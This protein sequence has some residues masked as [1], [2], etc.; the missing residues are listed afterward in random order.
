VGSKHALSLLAITLFATTHVAAQQTGTVSGTVVAAES[1]APLAGASVVMVGTARAVLTN[2]KGEYRLSVPAGAHSVRARHFGY[3]AGEQRITVA[4]GQTATADF[5]LTATPLAL[6]EV[7]VLGA[8]T[9]RTAVETPVPVDV[10]STQEIADNG[11]TEV[12][13]ILTT[14]APSFNASH[15]TI[16]DGTDH[17]DP[18]SL[19]GLGPDQVLVLVNGKRRHSSALVNVNGTFGR[20]TVGV[21]LNAIPTAAI[22]RIEVL[23]DGAAAQYGSDA[24]AGVINIVLKEQAEH[25]ELTTT[26]GT[27]SGGTTVGDITSRHDGDQIRTE[28]DYG[29]RLG[30]RGFFNVAG[31][32][33]HRGATSRAAPYSGND[34]FRGVTT[35]AGTDS[36]LLANG[37]T[38]EDFTIRLGQSAATVGMAFYNTVVPLSENAEFY[39]FGGI[40]HRDGRAAGF[41]RLPSQ[42]ARVVPQLYPFGFLPEIRPVLDDNAATAG[43]RGRLNGWDVDFS[44]TH[45]TNAL[46]YFVE[47]SNN[48]SMGTASPTTF[49][50]GRLA[51][52]Q[53]VG[54]LDVVRPLGGWAGFRSLSFVGGGEFRSE[55]YRIDAGEEASWQLGNGGNRPGIDFDT[56]STGLPKESGAQ[57]FPGFQPSNVL[58]RPRTNMSVYAGLE[59]QVSRRFLADI[60]GRFESYSDF[61]RTFNWKVAARLEVAPRVALRGAAS[62]GFRAPSLA[63]TWFN[64]VSNQFVIDASGNLI[65]NRILTSNNQSP[66]TKA[67]GVPALREETSRNYSLGLTAQPASSWAFTVDAYRITIDG[68]IVISSQFRGGTDPVGTVVARLLSPFQRLGVTTAQF[69]MN[70]VDTRTLGLDIVATHSGTLAG[71]TVTLTGAAT[72]TKTEVER[73]DIPQAMADTFTSGNLAAVSAILLNREDRNRLED[74]LPREKGSLT[75]RYGRGRFR[76][77]AR[78]TYYGTIFYRSPSGPANDETFDAKPLFDVDLDYE[79]SG[80]VQVAVGGAN[81]FNTFPDQQTKAANISLGR[82]IYSRRVTQFG[83]NGGFYYARVQVI[84]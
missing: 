32:Y 26:A 8:R 84:L 31:E 63:Q 23:R 83:M 18:A 33:L 30:E 77:L 25:V 73:V 76:G 79:L 3:E 5:K 40:S 74:A 13:Q 34:I 59:S 37:L 68:R 50:A 19:R 66:V 15:Q 69:F 51:F 71:G 64:N 41:Y 57:V 22:E 53:T 62:T 6:N 24:I 72:F 29:F 49:D 65:L 42:E 14:L 10:I 47:H 39:S 44:V 27:T 82:F 35:Q 43:V 78:G 17:I 11:Q 12:N 16:A 80:G 58:D 4:A 2:E 7:V 48:A 61:G 75:V 46:H 52:G 36:A 81:I 70:A 38:R 9:S 56:T 21:D 67:F 55:S 45:G 60:G 1:G 28:I 20:G 54:N